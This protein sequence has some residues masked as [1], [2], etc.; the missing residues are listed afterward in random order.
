[1]EL[2]DI[3][4]DSS[5]VCA[6]DTNVVGMGASHAMW[7]PA[8]HWGTRRT[9]SGNLGRGRNRALGEFG[10]THGQQLAVR[11]GYTQ[12]IVKKKDRRMCKSEPYCDIFKD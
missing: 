1:M 4:D 11:L 2:F 3:K 9:G 12:L 10:G 6:P 8:W 7:S 5:H